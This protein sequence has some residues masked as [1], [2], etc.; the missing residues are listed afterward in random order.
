MPL[1]LL[2]LL[3]HAHHQQT[4]THDNAEPTVA[5]AVV[6]AAA[7][8]PQKQNVQT[9]PLAAAAPAQQ[10]QCGNQDGGHKC[11]PFMGA[12]H[13]HV[14]SPN[15]WAMEVTT[16]VEAK[17]QASPAPILRPK[18]VV[19]GA[20]EATEAKDTYLSDTNGCGMHQS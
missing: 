2:L 16:L 4:T 12:G 17:V 7:P 11:T 14:H 6:A 8:A 20:V 13:T 15:F 9:Q 1:L 3:R 5:A 19:W 10:K 18:A